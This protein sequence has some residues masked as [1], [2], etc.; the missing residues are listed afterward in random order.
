MVHRGPD[1]VNVWKSP[2]NK[3]ILGHRRLAIIDLSPDGN[4]PMH[5]F[6]KSL[7]VV[8]NG[9]IYN[10]K[11]LKTVLQSKGHIFY[12]NSDTEVLLISYKEWGRKCLSKLNGMFTFAI[13]DKRNNTLFIARDRAGEKPLFYSF[14]NGTLKFASELKGLMQDVS[15]VRKINLNALDCFLSE[16]Y[17]PGDLCILNGIFKLPAGNYL[18]FDLN[19][20]NINESVYWDLPKLNTNFRCTTELLEELDYLLE[21][22]VKKQMISDVPI[23]VLLSGGID[24]SLVTAMAARVSSKIKTYTISFPGHGKLDESKHANLIASYFGTEHTELEAE[25]S[26]LDLL[27]LLARQ[28]DEPIIDSSMIPTYLVSKLVKNHCTVALGGDGAD[29]LFGVYSHY[30]KLLR[31]HNHTKYIPRLIR[32]PLVDTMEYITPTGYRGRNWLLAS[33]KNLDT[34][35]P[36]IANYFT[37]KERQKLLIN[38]N[39]QVGIAEEFRIKNISTDID[40]LQRATRKDFKSYLAED[41]LVKVDRASMLSS[42]EVRAPFLDYR[43]IDF[44]F[45]KVPSNLKADTVNRKIILKHLSTKLLPNEFDVNRKQGFSIPLSYWLETKEWSN[46]FKEVLLDK[47]QKIFNHKMI[48]GL[49]EGQKRG[50]NNGERLFGLV[51]FELW[52]NEYKVSI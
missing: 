14:V 31:L 21:D 34:S 45:S 3:L 7:T 11:E 37:K 4:Q 8:F 9:E 15:L 2:D 46:F 43:I 32:S 25:S 13:H 36:L 39:T 24:S 52:R 47:D 44:A 28:F 41:I 26:S 51:M 1:S 29:E 22:S 23:G 17:I 5:S 33:K 49:F 35:L 27:P 20:G 10:Y 42:L 19:N 48:E 18:I 30:S 12:T 50:R 6:D 16:G 40:L 38:S